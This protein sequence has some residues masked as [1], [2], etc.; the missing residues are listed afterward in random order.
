MTKI[1]LASDASA[2]IE[3]VVKGGNL[4]FI[5]T[6]AD[7]YENK[8]WI[9]EDKIKLAKKGFDL[10]EI[11]LKRKVSLKEFKYF[12]VVYVAGGNSFYLLEKMRE[13]GFG[14]MIKKLVDREVTYVGSSAGAVVAGP[15]IWPIRFLDDPSKAKLKSFKSLNLVDFIPLPHFGNKKYSKPYKKVMKGLGKTNY[16]YVKIKEN[17]AVL[18]KNGKV[19]IIRA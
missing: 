12:D 1:L 18:V 4:A 16:K 10:T 7:T 13:S 5:P 8:W 6:A 11:D 15:S 17:Q 9:K 3:K 19:K 2:L 14:R